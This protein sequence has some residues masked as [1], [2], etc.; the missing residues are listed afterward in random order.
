[1][2][3]NALLWSDIPLDSFLCVVKNFNECHD[4]CIKQLM[5]AQIFLEGGLSAQEIRHDCVLVG[6]YCGYASSGKVSADVATS[7]CKSPGLKLSYD[8]ECSKI[9]R[10]ARQSP[11][12]A[13]TNGVATSNG[14]HGANGHAVNG[15]APA[16][17]KL[18]LNAFVEMC[19]YEVLSGSGEKHIAEHIGRFWPP[20][21]RSLAPSRRSIFRL[22]LR[23][24]LDQARPATGERAL[25]RHVHCGRTRRLRRLRWTEE[26][27][28]CGQEWSAM[29]SQ[30]APL[31]CSCHG[32]C[33]EESGVWCHN[34]DEL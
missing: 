31:C 32:C 2:Q 10:I 24:A 4:D 23:P 16:K 13:I 7:H 33:D 20:K 12:M 18:I 6:N 17:K 8:A 9:W 26:P 30:R 14:T 5:R 29:A 11:E 28:P 27:R 25:P 22:H 19:E 34:H 15:E 3:R 21:S 1:M